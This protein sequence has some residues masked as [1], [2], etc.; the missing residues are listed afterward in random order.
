MTW[1]HP[2]TL[3]N[4]VERYEQ[5]R[6]LELAGHTDPQLQAKLRDTAYTLC[7]ST[8]TRHT[9]LALAVARNRIAES[10]TEL[11]EAAS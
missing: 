6:S 5:L 3:T 9:G 2:S 8:G 11:A 1:A 10:R 7:V 4:L